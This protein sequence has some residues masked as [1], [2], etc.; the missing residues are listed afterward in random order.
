VKAKID[1]E[2]ED[3]KIMDALPWQQALPME[4]VA[5]GLDWPSLLPG[6]AFVRGA[7]GGISVS[8][9]MFN[10]ARAGGAATSA[11]EFALHASQETRTKLESAGTIGASVL[12]S[13]MIGAGG[14]KVFP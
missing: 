14:V 2:N 7:Q 8:R 11:Q 9:S 5:G 6:G 1:R 3:R 10:V 12:L 4:M 13:G